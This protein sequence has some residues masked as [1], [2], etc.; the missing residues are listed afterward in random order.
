M[1]WELRLV[2]DYIMAESILQSCETIDGP[3]KNSNNKSQGISDGEVVAIYCYGIRCG[4][5]NVKLIHKFSSEMLSSWFPKIPSYSQFILRINALAEILRFACYI[6][7][8]ENE[9]RSKGD[10]AVIDSMPISVASQARSGRAKA[11]KGLAKKGYCS[12]KKQYYYGVKLHAVVVGKNQAPYSPTMIV[13]TPANRHDIDVLKDNYDNIGAAKIIGD[14]AYASR[15]LGKAAR[16]V[17]KQVI[18]PFKKPRK[19]ELTDPK[20]KR[21]RKVSKVRQMIETTFGW[22]D[23][24]TGIHNASKV[25]SKQ[26]LLRHIYGALLTAMTSV[27]VGI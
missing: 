25:R 21:N 26:G 3:L 4:M 12:S 1:D 27:P 6:I 24:M 10:C 22:I 2:A 11:A 23:Q 14:K 17:G 16:A 20:K 18:T 5:R 15:E 19:K 7:A 13:V 9:F 8:Q